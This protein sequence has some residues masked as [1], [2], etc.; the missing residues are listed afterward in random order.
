MKYNFLL[1]IIWSCLILSC[2]PNE[3]KSSISAN[4]PVK[5]DLEAFKK[6]FGKAVRVLPNKDKT[7]AAILLKKKES[8]F[9]YNNLF[10]LDYKTQTKSFIAP[11]RIKKVEWINNNELEITIIQGMPAGDGTN[12]TYIHNTATLKTSKL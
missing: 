8:G 2:K 12:N 6:E 11:E 5:V 10:V 9:E 7:F 1:L 3:N 4:N